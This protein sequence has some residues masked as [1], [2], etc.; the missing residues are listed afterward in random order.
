MPFINISVKKHKI[1]PQD[2]AARNEPSESKAPIYNE[3]R[4]SFEWR[5]VGHVGVGGDMRKATYD[6]TDS[7]IVDNAGAL[8]GSTL[9]QVRDH[10]PKGHSNEAHLDD[11]LTT[12]DKY[13]KELMDALGVDVAT[14][15]GQDFEGV[16][17][18]A[19]ITHNNDYHN[20]TF[21][22]TCNK[23]TKALMDALDI[24][25]A[26]LGGKTPGV[27]TD[28][29]AFYDANGRVADVTKVKGT[30]VDATNIGAGK[31]LAYDATTETLVYKTLAELVPALDAEEKLILT[32]SD[33]IG[34]KTGDLAELWDKTTK[35]TTADFEATEFDQPNKIPTLDASTLLSSSQVVGNVP[36]LS[37]TGKL[38]LTQVGAKVTDLAAL[39]DKTTKL[40][41][42]DFD[43]ATFN[44]ANGMVKLDASVKVPYTLVPEVGGAATFVIA[45]SNSENKDKADYVCT[46]TDDQGTIE[47]A[48][49]AL[50]ANGGSIILLEGTYTID[51]NDDPI[52]VN[53]R[54]NITLQGQGNGTK[55]CLG[56][57]IVT[58]VIEVINA[59]GITIRDMYID[60]TTTAASEGDDLKQC[61]II[62][63]TTTDSKIRNVC[64]ASNK[65]HGINIY[66]SSERNT[67][68][69]CTCKDNTF[70]GLFI[71]DSS[72]Y[73]I[74]WQNMLINNT[75]SGIFIYANCENNTAIGNKA[76]GNGAVGIYIS[77]ANNNTV[78][79]NTCND[80][81]ND[82]IQL[83][84]AEYNTIT[85]N[86]CCNNSTIGVRCDSNTRYNTISGNTTSGNSGGIYLP[87]GDYNLISGNVCSNNTTHG[88]IYALSAGLTISGNTCFNNTD[89][90]ITLI[91]YGQNVVSGN[92]CCDNTTTGVL[93][94]QNLKYNTIVGN[95]LRGN[96]MNGIYGYST[97]YNTIVSNTSRDNQRYGIDIYSAC[98]NNIIS[99]NASTGNS[100]ITDNL[101]DN[102]AIRENSD[103]NNI[104]KNTCRAGSGAVT[105]RYGVN[106]LNSNCT[107]NFVT[108]NDV[109]NDNYGTGSL[110]FAAG[111]GTVTTPGNRTA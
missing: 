77:T 89:H 98:S 36:G 64:S 111:S 81:N 41:T 76:E 102:I 109:Y 72:T 87:W 13:S 71:A 74:L 75:I 17:N 19:P 28:N 62:L 12:C 84:D 51:A 43:D 5:D 100:Q 86:S 66:N 83:V 93:L 82:G 16:H 61:G 23:Y 39:W 57:G 91:A 52:I 107:E 25:A 49:A 85:G 14:L 47:A 33:Q 2:V 55:L 9:T 60:G 46:G 78:V 65:R 38:I 21:L 59:S 29:I 11:L 45:A 15:E 31:L 54:N 42:T 103:Y 79:G 106:V 97:S 22:A 90:G 48:I 73:N 53:A 94:Y 34:T 32:G 95:T 68:I 67:V 50:P 7:G 105:P 88:G 3:G 108:N 4:H 101:Y 40:I 26:T 1:T 6:R 80:N 58:N 20:K 8:Q 24:D 110:N 44:V 99:S 69:N 30:T 70:S 10:A 37:G 27:G 104:Q 92:S 56:T 18:H 96:G 35:L 63:F